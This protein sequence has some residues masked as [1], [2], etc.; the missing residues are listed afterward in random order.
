MKIIFGC[1]ALVTVL[2]AIILYLFY[3]KEK[4]EQR[5]YNAK[6]SYNDKNFML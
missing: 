5:E 3:R 2:L 4:K 1:L 6:D